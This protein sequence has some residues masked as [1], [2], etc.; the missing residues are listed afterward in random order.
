LIDEVSG[1]IDEAENLSY[2]KGPVRPGG[3]LLHLLRTCP[4]LYGDLSARS[5]LAALT[6]DPPFAWSF[7]EEF[8]DRLLLGLDYCSPEDDMPHLAWLRAARDEGH[9][10][11]KAFDKIT[12]R[13]IAAIV[14][15][16]A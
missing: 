8:Q 15:L 4:N 2:P 5:G 9:L 13:N 3:R 16:G 14:G 6:R 12:G 11:T 10:S 7:L 1:D